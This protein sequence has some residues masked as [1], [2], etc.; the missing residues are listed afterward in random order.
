MSVAR[1]RLYGVARGLYVPRPRPAE[2]SLASAANASSAEVFVTSS[3]LAA[4]A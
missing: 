2:V 1:V 4:R 3:I